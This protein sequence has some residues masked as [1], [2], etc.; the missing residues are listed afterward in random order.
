MKKLTY[1]I[2]GA[3]A[4]LFGIFAF[5][6][7]WKSHPEL[8]SFHE[9]NQMF[10]FSSDYFTNTISV[11]GGLADYISEYLVQFYFYTS[12]G[13]AIVALVLVSLQV[14]SSKALRSLTETWQVTPYI[15]SWLITILMG[16]HMMDENTLLSFP[17]AIILSL[18]TY[19]ACR[20]GG[21][22]CQL[23]ASLP[24]YWLVGLA[25][26]IQVALAIADSWREKS[27]KAAILP[28]CVLILVAAGWFYACRML[29]IA[30]YPWDTVLAGINYHR[31]TIM[32]ME[33]PS[34]QNA[35]LGASGATGNAKGFAHGRTSN[36]CI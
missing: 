3:I 21:W 22:I 25:F 35:I 27:W 13:A 36:V 23:V 18:L 16:L 10:L 29:W 32:S 14:L 24:L 34:L 15:M 12:A 33:A 6:F 31:L 28:S 4:L 8:L 7:A 9:Q 5:L 19:L 26:I 1:I 30:Q 11:A 20:R 17:I 2:Q